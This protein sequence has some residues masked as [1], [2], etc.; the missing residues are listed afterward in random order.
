M[1]NSNFAFGKIN[2]I[3]LVV[4]MLIVVSGFILMSGDGTTEEAFN[5]EIFSNT[6][7]KVAP[8]TCLFGFIFVVA[9]VIWK[10]GHREIRYFESAEPKEEEEA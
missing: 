5:P 6:R 2:Y 9:A 4:G 7:I 1:D 3:L 8:M 10:P